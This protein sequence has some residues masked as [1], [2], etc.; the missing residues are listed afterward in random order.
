MRLRLT[1]IVSVMKS[2]WTYG[3]SFFGYTEELNDN[4]NT[5]YPSMLVTPPDSV[6]PEFRSN[7]GWEEFTFNIFFSDLYQR[8]QQ[9]NETIEQRWDNLQDLASEW[10]DMFLRNYQDSTVQGWLDDE[11]LTIERRKEVAND[12]LLQI[13]MSFTW[14]ANTRCFMPFTEYPSDISDLVV[15]LKADSG[16]TYSIATKKV[17]L[18]LDQSGV[19][20][21]FR[22]DSSV[23]DSQPLRFSYDGSLDKTRLSFD[24]V[25][26]FLQ[27]SNLS[28]ITGNNMT[29]FYVAKANAT[30]TLVQRVVGYRESSTPATAD[31]LNFGVSNNGRLLFKVID[32]N[33]IAGS[34]TTNNLELGTSFHI[35]SARIN[36]E[37]LSVQYN[38]NSE[39]AITV[40]GF[41]NDDGFAAERL[42]IGSILFGDPDTHFNGDV[43]E[44][45]IYNKALSNIERDLV[46]N[47][48]N[49]KFKI[50]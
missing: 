49:R 48:L 46:R 42:R 32:D 30:S 47:Y 8:T 28:P 24:G 23:T 5:K 38:N 10:L 25:N 36:G 43:Q 11:S 20:N 17:S 27:S 41:N 37:T 26:D 7:N 12:Q 9:A 22:E 39:H 34:I 6:F 14:K 44:V 33:G 4:H 21:H 15:W 1:D 45:I 3:D 50:Y 19:G 29:I 35:A 2:K 40:S 13:R 16:L 18:W 31:R